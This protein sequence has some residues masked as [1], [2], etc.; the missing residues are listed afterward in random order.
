VAH[1]TPAEIDAALGR[2]AKLNA[3]AYEHVRESEARALGMRVSILDAAVK[4]HRNVSQPSTTTQGTALDLSATEPWDGPV[5]GGAMM[6]EL[7]A[8][9]RRFVVLPGGADVVIALWVVMTHAIDA[10]DVAPILAVTAPEKGCGKTTVLDLVGRLVERP[11]STSNISSAALF[12]TI[13]R[14]A[15]T[16][17]IDEFDAFYRRNDELRGVLNSGHTRQTAYVIRCVGDEAEPRRFSTWSAKAIAGIGGLPPTLS[18]RSIAIRLRRALPGEATGIQKLRHA[19][20]EDFERL[21]RMAS[22]WALDHR[23]AVRAAR[24]TTPQQLSNRAEDNAAPLLAIAEVIGGNLVERARSAVVAILCDSSDEMASAGQLLLRDVES[25]FVERAVD[26]LSTENM[27]QALC[28][29]EDAPW[30]T[31]SNGAP[32]T[33]HMLAMRLRSYGIKPEQKRCSGGIQRGYSRK[34][35]GDAARRYAITQK[36]SKESVTTVTSVTAEEGASLGTQGVTVAPN[37]GSVTHA[38]QASP[39]ERD[40]TNVPEVTITSDPMACLIGKERGSGYAF[41]KGMANG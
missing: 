12:R 31:A 13:N 32:L 21:K 1:I 20:K 39:C 33:P 41:G 40:E 3:L 18:D 7:C 4:R 25:I 35:I 28:L 30:A 38:S 6:E 26:W 14:C 16:L 9:I 5:E 8:L 10:L 36:V 22:R 24:P 37:V 17:L 27:L 2:L 29:L 19:P 23:D 11:L 34:P 15:P